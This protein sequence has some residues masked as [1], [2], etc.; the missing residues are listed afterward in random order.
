MTRA[1]KLLLLL[2]VMAADTA[3][4]T[5]PSTLEVKL[6]PLA[7]R[8]GAVLFRTRYTVNREGA[9]RFM[10]VEFGWLVVDARGGWKEVP[11]RTV[12]EPASP[13]SAEE[14]TRAWAELKRADAEFKAPLDWK[15]PPESLAGLLR[16]YGFTRKDVV[17]KNA[18]AGTVTWSPKTLCE[19]KRCPSPCRQRTVRE[20][21]SEDV[22]E[23]EGPHKP[24]K[25]LFVHSGVAVFRNQYDDEHH[26][27]FFTE[28]VVGEEDRNPGIEIH[29][30][31]AICVVPR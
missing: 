28:P 23:G 8:K 25:A 24:I 31:M 11:H 5:G 6:S 14:D 3:G 12:A 4:A 30:V 21:R 29:D 19:G 15:A 22:D 7:A 1:L 2:G 27:A 17:A 10:T 20:W 9:H 13:G 26:D 18:G 16:E